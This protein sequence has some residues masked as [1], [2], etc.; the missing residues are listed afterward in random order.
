VPENPT[1]NS[2][3]AVLQQQRD[4]L[5]R[6]A[7]LQ[8]TLER[9]NKT[10]QV[11]VN[12]PVQDRVFN[13]IE[14]GAIGIVVLSVVVLFYSRKFIGDYVSKALLAFE[15]VQAMALG[16]ERR[17]HESRE[18]DTALMRK[19]DILLLRQHRMQEAI[20]PGMPFT[21]RHDDELHT[22]EEEAHEQH[23]GRKP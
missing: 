13:A 10:T 21:E 4:I 8:D 3:E 17:I 23:E 1:E 2:V 5:E 18:F 12:L 22:L 9:Q 15:A 11:H 20:S 6:Q 16:A 7:Q 19:V 14:N